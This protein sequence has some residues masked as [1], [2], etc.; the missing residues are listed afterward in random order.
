MQYLRRKNYKKYRS[1]SYEQYE[2]QREREEQAQTGK[3]EQI[4]ETPVIAP[5]AQLPETEG[6][7]EDLT[8]EEP[9]EQRS[10]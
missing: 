3:I 2:Q 10:Y 5:Q 4:V 7:M 1:V 8:A 9:Q 6:S